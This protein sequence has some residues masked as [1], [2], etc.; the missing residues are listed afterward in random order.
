MRSVRLAHPADFDGWRD[1]ARALDAAEVPP[2]EVVWRVGD[3][4]ADLFAGE[5]PPG[6]RPQGGERR[7]PRRFV[8]LAR[9][10]VCHRDEER[11]AR[12][13]G[14]LRRLRDEPHLLA[15]ASDP[16]VAR[17][18]QMEREVRRAMHKMK[19]FVRFRQVT[20]MPGDE[21]ETFVA[22]FEPEHHIVDEVAPFFA[23]RFASMRWSIL[24]PLR[25]AHWDGRTLSIAGGAGRD[26]APA[27]DRL[28]EVW[29]TYFSAIFNPARLKVRAMRSE[30]PRKYWHN[31]PE[32]R[33][34]GPLIR[35]ASDRT[36]RMIPDPSTRNEPEREPR[37]EETAME[38]RASLE[39]LQECR[40]CPLYRD[41]TQA[42]GGEGPGQARI[43]MVG[44]QPGD[45]EDLAGR[46]FVGPAGRLLDRALIDAGVARESVYVTNAVKHFKFFVRGKRRIHQ[47]PDHSEIEQCRWWLDIERELIRPEL[48]VALGAS[49]AFSLM[50]RTVTIK[51]VRGHI[52]DGPD[53]ASLLVTVH[54]SYLLRLPDEAAKASEYRRFVDD[55]RL[56]A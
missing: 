50:R 36:Q 1:A 56:A 51:S 15:V 35:S 6:A 24:T 44:E 33:A 53:G 41:A 34:I 16:D 8:E 4:A 20:P 21:A 27:D 39:G 12:A 2:E 43:M 17:A 40:R 46:P 25:S 29:R 45:Q 30:M 18:A 19:A 49:A 54:P 22:W 31:L 7:V 10:L 9:L 26:D 38:E 55:L 13:Y 32:A 23:R 3:E 52:M 48:I 11:F 37:N 5:A 47:K 28:E 42:V 14:L